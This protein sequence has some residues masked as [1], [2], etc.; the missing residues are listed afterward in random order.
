MA[1]YVVPP[2]NGA[3]EEVENLAR[4]SGVEVV[5]IANLYEMWPIY[6]NKPHVIVRMESELMTLLMN[7]AGTLLDEMPTVVLRMPSTSYNGSW[8]M[9]ANSLPHIMWDQLENELLRSGKLS[10][11]PSEA[12][13]RSD[14]PKTD[15]TARRHNTRHQKQT[16]VSNEDVLNDLDLAGDDLDGE[17]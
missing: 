13:I 11:T 1:L 6:K 4:T 9:S 5:S 2:N 16:H 15:H 17:S 10:S 7:H 12:E 3:S 8:M 14:A